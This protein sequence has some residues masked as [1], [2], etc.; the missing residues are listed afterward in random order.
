MPQKMPWYHHIKTFFWETARA[1]FFF[2]TLKSEC[3]LCVYGVLTEFR[4]WVHLE[5]GNVSGLGRAC[6]LGSRMA[7]LFSARVA[8]LPA[9]CTLTHS[10]P[11]TA[12]TG[13]INVH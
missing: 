1:L 4:L 13:I 6:H 11:Y 2:F 5:T 3:L 8:S 7:H 12:H 10:Q 9:G